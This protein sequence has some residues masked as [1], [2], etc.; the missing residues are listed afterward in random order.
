MRRPRSFRV[1]AIVILATGCNSQQTDAILIRGMNING[2]EFDYE[3]RSPS[4]IQADSR[5]VH[6]SG[7][8]TKI[9]VVEGKLRVDGRSFGLVKQ[10]DRISVDGDK[11]SVNGEARKNGD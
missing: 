5:A 2:Y 4:S 10:N 3:M 1:I 8:K 11:V 9:E 6:I 7:G